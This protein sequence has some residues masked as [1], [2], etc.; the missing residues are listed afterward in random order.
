MAPTP[1]DDHLDLLPRAVVWYALVLIVGY[2]WVTIAQGKTPDQV[3]VISDA[4]A[5]QIGPF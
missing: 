4:A 1:C 3:P 5:M 2:S